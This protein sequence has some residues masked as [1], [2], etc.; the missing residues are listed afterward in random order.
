MGDPQVTMGF[1]TKSGSKDL[2]L[3]GGTPNT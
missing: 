1:N 2:D 3:L